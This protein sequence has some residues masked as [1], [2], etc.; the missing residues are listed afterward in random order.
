MKVLEILHRRALEGD[1]DVV[2]VHS[3][4]LGW[5][6]GEDLHDLDPVLHGQVVGEGELRRHADCGHFERGAHEPALR[7]Q[8]LH[9]RLGIID[10]DHE[11]NAVARFHVPRIDPNHLPAKVHS[12][13]RNCPD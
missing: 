9:D 12:G 10:R 7:K 5:S 3:R 11:T 13:P 2:G 8:D 4:L 1:D 6:A